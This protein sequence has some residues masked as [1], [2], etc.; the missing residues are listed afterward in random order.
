[1]GG[2]AEESGGHEN[3]IGYV[4]ELPWK[5]TNR[6]LERRGKKRTMTLAMPDCVVREILNSLSCTEH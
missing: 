2:E 4:D 1:M 5:I 6:R 3:N